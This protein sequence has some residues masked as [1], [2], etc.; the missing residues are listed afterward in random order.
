MR[1]LFLVVPSFESLPLTG[2]ATPL[3]MGIITVIG[4]NQR[5]HIFREP[6]LAPTASSEREETGLNRGKFIQLGF[7]RESSW[8]YFS[9]DYSRSLR[10]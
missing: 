4:Y 5:D 7:C 10:N 1:T 6:N 3:T 8:K 9:V 2:T